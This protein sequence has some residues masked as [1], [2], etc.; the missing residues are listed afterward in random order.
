MIDTTTLDPYRMIDV[1]FMTYKNRTPIS[2]VLINRLLSSPEWHEQYTAYLRH[3]L[4][5]L[6]L[7]HIQE[8]VDRICDTLVRE[9]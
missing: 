6:E 4:P 3:Y 7:P 1:D 9:G 8:F 5:L 2:P